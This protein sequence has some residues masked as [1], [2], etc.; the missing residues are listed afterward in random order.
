MA[1]QQPP[2]GWNVGLWVAQV[3][4]ALMFG[5]AGAMKTFTPIDQLAENLPWVSHDIAWLVRFIGI[6]ELLGAIGVIAP[7][8]TRIL[9]WLTPLAGAC[10]TLVMVLAFG[11]HVSRGEFANLPVNVVLGALGVLVAWGRTRK[12]PIAPRS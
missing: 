2:K 3:V 8:A 1:D 9:P 12:A 7:A 10:L 11:F 4:L 5:L 6:S